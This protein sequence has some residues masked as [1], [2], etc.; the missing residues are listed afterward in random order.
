MKKQNIKWVA[1]ILALLLVSAEL[2]ARY[3][4]GLGT[5]PVFITHPT[6][7]YQLK[8][9]QDVNRFGNRVLINHYGMRSENFDSKKSNTNELRVLV[10]GDSVI[11]GGS[12]TDHNA[13]ATT[14][15]QR[16][17]QQKTGQPVIVAN[18][19]AGSWGPGN[20]LAYVKEYG[21][22]DA[23]IV[24]LVAS[25]HDAYDAPTFEPLNS[26]THPQQTPLSA[27]VEGVDRY[28]PRYLP[29][30]LNVKP[31]VK[32]VA[33]A[34]VKNKAS[35][36]DLHEFLALVKNKIGKVIVFLHPTKLEAET[37]TMEEGYSELVT[38]LKDENVSYISMQSIFHKEV[39][40]QEIYREND[41]IHPNLIG[42]N[43]I[44]ETIENNIPQPWLIPSKTKNP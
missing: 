35:L 27:L 44:A 38:L 29:G 13:L 17:W 34:P 39:A 36:E 3:Y 37:G 20:W 15:L 22:F 40:K 19:S 23:D 7:E 9:D 8:P 31:E 42:Q 32:V 2:F 10:F 28:L 14:L 41:I 43:I 16:R 11:N 24:V 6:I 4:L 12:L 21:L 25:S 1:L 26:D 18:I 30:W 5:P 33:V